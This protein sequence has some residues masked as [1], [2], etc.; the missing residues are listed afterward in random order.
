MS[1]R[2]WIEGLLESAAGHDS[3][4][5]TMTA[6]ESFAATISMKSPG[7]RTVALWDL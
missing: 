3:Y 7:N 1:R 2:P 6:G 5:H 4:V